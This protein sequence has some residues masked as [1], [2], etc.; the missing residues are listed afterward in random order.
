[1]EILNS[2]NLW[3]DWIKQYQYD[4]TYG[5]LIDPHY[6]VICFDNNS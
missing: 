2:I 6:K 5:Y 1:M 3:V 4:P